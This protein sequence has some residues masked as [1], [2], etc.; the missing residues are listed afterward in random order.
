MKKQEY[1]QLVDKV[2]NLIKGA[3]GE[4]EKMKHFSGL[5]KES[6]LRELPKHK[7]TIRTLKGIIGFH[8]YLI[9]E[10]DAIPR[11]DFLFNAL[12][13]VYECKKNYKEKWYSPR[14]S[15]F[16]DYKA[17]EEYENNSKPA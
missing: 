12:H 1:N 13:D 9:T 7:E 11:S 5:W 10:S 15:R 17:K 2:V 4:D 8:Q 3:I 14:L 16:A 6:D